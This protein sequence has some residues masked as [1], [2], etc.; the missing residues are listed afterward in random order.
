MGTD[1]ALRRR[2]RRLR[3]RRSGEADALQPAPGRRVRDA[4]G[5][6]LR[7][8]GGQ[9]D[10]HRHH[11]GARRR[12]PGAQGRHR[13][14]RRPGETQQRGGQGHGRRG[15][16][17]RRA[18]A[19]R[20]RDPRGQV[21]RQGPTPAGVPQPPVPLPLRQGRQ[22][23]VARGSPVRPARPAG[24]GPPGG[25]RPAASP[26]FP[27]RLARR[28][29]PSQRNCRH[30]PRITPE[31]LSTPRLHGFITS[32]YV[33]DVLALLTIG[34]AWVMTA[35]LDWWCGAG[36]CGVVRGG[37]VRGGAERGG[38]GRGGAGRCGAGW[39]GA[40]RSGAWC[41]LAWCGLAWCELAWCGLAWS[42]LAWSGLAWSGLAWCGAWWPG[43]LAGEPGDGLLLGLV[44]VRWMELAPEQAL[45]VP[46]GTREE[47]RAQ[48][49]PA[50]NLPLPRVE[51][52]VGV[53]GVPDVAVDAASRSRRGRRRSSGSWPGRRRV[54]R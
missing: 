44:V 11:P 1:R 51:D 6:L 36:W 10:R 9:G 24:H 15:L 26:R 46:G 16:V 41:E 8:Q 43:L 19:Q 50:G 45:A 23:Q 30:F 20:D 28:K 3:P 54:R 48:E 13:R 38:A 21:A 42:G 2:P 53:E 32:V 27:A 14:R 12:R 25:L 39:C 35:G 37:V 49:R 47:C 33:Y 52:P 22:R 4:L 34:T 7:H 31:L 40:V 5:R 18:G 17:R 29:L